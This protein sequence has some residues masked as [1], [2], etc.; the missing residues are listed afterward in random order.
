[1]ALK[2]VRSVRS[3]AKSVNLPGTMCQRIM[4]ASTKHTHKQQMCLTMPSI[5]K[6]QSI[7][8]LDALKSALGVLLQKAMCGRNVSAVLHIVDAFGNAA[9]TGGADV[10]AQLQTPDS[11][12]MSEVSHCCF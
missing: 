1:M 6:Q 5:Y 3:R 8:M 7:F 11:T 12:M 9:L 2:A 4:A 10:S